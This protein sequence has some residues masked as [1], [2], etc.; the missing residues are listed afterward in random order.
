MFPEVR[1]ALPSSSLG[2]NILT[3][4]ARWDVKGALEKVAKVTA[5]CRGLFTGG[6][7]DE[8]R[9]DHRTSHTPWHCLWSRAISSRRFWRSGQHQGKFFEHVHKIRQLALSQQ[10]L[11]QCYWKGSYAL[12]SQLR[13]FVQAYTLVSS[14]CEWSYRLQVMVLITSMTGTMIKTGRW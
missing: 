4:L 11:K 10:H 9:A 14:D 7:V 1:T 6:E 3:L 12:Q 13:D 8:H 5:P 2:W